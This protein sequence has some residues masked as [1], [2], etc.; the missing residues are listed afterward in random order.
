MNRMRMD[1]YVDGYRVDSVSLDVYGFG[2]HPQG[3]LIR[4]SGQRFVRRLILAGHDVR[5]DGA[6]EYQGRTDR[7][8]IA[9]SRTNR[10]FCRTIGDE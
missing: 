5:I 9:L 1:V 8:L 6:P 3:R 4:G 7:R 2:S 10:L